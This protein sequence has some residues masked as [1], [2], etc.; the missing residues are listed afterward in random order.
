M[1]YCIWL[2]SKPTERLHAVAQSHCAI[3]HPLDSDLAPAAVVCRIA[4]MADGKFG[5]DRGYS[6]SETV[7]A[8]T[9]TEYC[10]SFLYDE[11]YA[12]CKESSA[13]GLVLLLLAAACAVLPGVRMCYKF[14]IRRSSQSDKA[15]DASSVV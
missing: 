9:W 7:C 11:D 2:D 12:K 13:Y 4:L 6:Y 3:Q 8:A 1:V 5:T 15:A 14:K 10:G